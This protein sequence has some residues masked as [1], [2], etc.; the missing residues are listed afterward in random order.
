VLKGIF[1]VPGDGMIDFGPLVRRLA[2]IGYDGWFVVEAEQ[3]PA[4]APPLEYARLGHRA[5]TQALHQ[6]GYRIEGQS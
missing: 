4:K 3:D 2:G 5:L 6:A 1:T